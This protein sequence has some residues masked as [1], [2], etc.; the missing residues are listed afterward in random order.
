MRV[1]LVALE[2][3]A[4]AAANLARMVAWANRLADE[5]VQLVVFPEACLTG[6]VNDDDPAH[7]LA[8]GSPLPGPVLDVL[9]RVARGRGVHIAFGLLER[10][11]GRLFDTAVLLDDRG[12]VALHYRRIT[13]GWH[14]RLADPAVYGQGYDLPVA[15][16]GLG[17][18]ACLLCGDLF[19]DDVTD[20]ARG[21][22]IDWLLFPLWRCVDDNALA[23]T[24]WAEK[25]E[26]VY[27]ARVARV[28]CTTFMVNALADATL[29]G[30][31]FGGAWVRAPDGSPRA[32]LAIGEAG[33]LLVDV[34]EA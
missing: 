5:A 2:I 33:A 19:D 11:A 25:E 24:Q 27:A 28:G 32:T 10:D 16:T 12:E 7:D 15:E 21:L 20:R 8:L 13:P 22:V 31:A 29:R 30:G 14:G 1:G 26:S 23:R 18:F 9:A 17:R 6:L 34:G 4:H 3:Q